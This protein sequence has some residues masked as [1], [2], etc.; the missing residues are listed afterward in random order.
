MKGA[1]SGFF[2]CFAMVWG[3][4]QEPAKKDSVTVLE[5]VI[6]LEEAIKKKAN[7]I[8]PSEIIGPKIFRNYS[9][10]DAA[11]IINQIPGVYLLSGALNTNRI[12][13]RGIGARTPFG[14]DKLRLY[15]N[16]IPVTNGTGS[17]TLEAYDI[18]NLGS[19][20]IIKGPK[21]S[22]FGTNLGGAILLNTKE[23]IDDFT[24]FTNNFT[25][26]SYGLLKNNLSF[27]HND[28]KLSFGIRYGHLNTNGFR[29]NNRFQRDGFLLNSTF[30][31]NMKNSITFLL[32][33]IDYTA[34]IPSSLGETDFIENPRQAAFTWGASQGFEANRYT[35]AGLSY[36]HSFDTSLE[37]TTSVFYTY[38]DHYEPRPFNILD[39]FTNGYGFRTSFSGKLSFADYTI[40]AELYKDEYNWGTFEN[41][42]QENNGNGSLQGNRISKNKE[43]RRQSN[44]FGTFTYPFTSRFSVQLG[45]NLNQTKYDFRD[46]FNTDDSN[47]NA[48]RNFNAIL[49]P[50]FT[51]EYKLSDKSS[52]YGN[53]SRGFSNPSLEETL[54]PDGVINPDIAQEK[55]INYEIGSRL[56][57]LKKRLSVNL[58]LYQMDVN[59]LLV[60]QRVG[61]D[62]FIGRNAGKTRHQGIDLAL[63]Y[64]AAVTAK[65]TLSPFLNYTLSNHSFIDFVDGDDDFSGN[66][67][68]GVP[69]HR[70]NTG[71]QLK[72]SAG[73]YWNIIHQFVDEISLT[74]ANTLYSDSFNIFNTR[75]GYQKQVLDNF[76]IGVDFGINNIMNTLYAQSVLINA[77]SFGGNEPRYFYPGNDRNFYG[78]IQLK[79]TL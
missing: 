32:N 67:L 29:E 78:S 60:A 62:Q 2:L 41:L 5:E 77:R 31:I 64:T 49:L 26:G 63:T 69:K 13:I 44:I 37:N 73:F 3:I 55:G 14:T 21:G 28:D 40:G 45:L 19:I 9:P 6:L 50:N 25:F 33:H 12:T 71:I 43:F 54:T 4:A 72:H 17:S 53:I 56:T 30:K 42:Y 7:G 58:A 20:E 16:G 61:D 11:S 24:R 36:T 39:E 18:E 27:E 76:S 70:I 22:A 47:K 59:D 66:P 68:T 51:L 23:S 46:L 74:D 57:L 79:Y 35:L 65:L 10:I 1:I 8:T 48:A 34:Q 52:F 75:M 15:F 38:L